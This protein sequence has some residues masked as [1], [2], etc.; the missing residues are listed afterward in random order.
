MLVRWALCFLLFSGVSFSATFG[1]VV[2]VLG[3]ATDI[4]LDEGRNRIYLVNTNQN[5]VE[6]YSIQQRR[7]L[8]PILTDGVPLTAAISRSGQFLYVTSQTASGIDVIDL[9]SQTVVNRLSLPA[10]PEGI[11]VGGD[12]RVLISTIGS[13]AGNQQNVLLIYDPNASPTMALLP[14]SV[15]PLPPVPPQLPPPSGKQFQATRATLRVSPDGN[16]IIGVNIPINGAR[17]VFVYEVASGTVLRSRIVLNS[18][19]VLAVAPDGSKFMSGSTLFDTGTLQVL[20][21]ENMA[22]APYL[23]APG[24]AFNAESTQGGS[25][26]SPDGTLLFAGFDSAPQTN[27]PSP[28]NVSQLL[29]NDPDNLLIQTALQLPEN[30]SGKMVMSSDGATIY[31]LSESGF[32]ILPLAA[33]QQNPLAALDRTV[34]VLA[35]DQCGVTAAQRTGRVSVVN[36]GTG[37]LTA[38]AQVTAITIGAPF[39]GIPGLPI[40]I[41]PQAAAPQVR[42]QQTGSGANIDFTFNPAAAN[43]LGTTAPG[44]DFT[45]QSPEAINIPARVHVYQNNRNAEAIGTIMPLP[46]GVSTAEGLQDIVYDSSRQRLYISNS[47]MNRVEVFD[48]RQNRF[49]SPIK[50]GQLPHSMAL[51]PDGNT[52]YVANTGGESISIVDPDQGQAVGRVRFPPLPLTFASVLTTPGEIAAGQRGPLFIMNTAA[53]NGLGTGT[54]WQVIG[55]EAV[56]R[57]ASQVIGTTNGFPRAIPGPRSMV[58]TPGGEFILL[59]GSDGFAYLYDSSADDFVQAKQLTAIQASIGYFGPASAGPRGQYFVVNGN[60]LNQELTAINSISRTP[61]VTTRPISAVTAMSATTYLRFTTP[62][63][64]NLNVAPTDAGT[65]EM[66]DVITGLPSRSIPALE[67]PMTQVTVNQRA[68]AI[69]SRTIAIDSSGNTAYALTTSGLSIIS[70]NPPA[71]P[72]SAPQVFAKG[73]VNAASY[74]VGVAQNGIASIFGRNLGDS[75]SAATFPLPTVMGGLCVTLNST[76]LPLFMT[77]PGQINLQIPPELAIGNYALVIR[78]IGKSVA[79]ASQTLAVAKYAPAV[80]VDPVTNQAALLHAS[81]GSFVTH[82]H[83]AHR[84][85]SLMLFATGLGLTTGGKVTGGNPSPSNPLAVTAPVEVFFGNPAWKQAGIIVDW[86]GLAPGFVGLYQLNLRVP[87][88]HINGDAVPITLRIGSVSSPSSG[89]VLPVAAVE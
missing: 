46:L 22:N 36:V 85:E 20:A 81:D 65:L 23:I 43:A 47:G 14:V 1:T 69:G 84:D 67:G 83:P 53:A 30:L 80:F 50:V 37:R 57:P 17:V 48:I 64:T 86:S 19:G 31:A 7:L 71:A 35:N 59:A 38:T 5:R 25:V 60:V 88:D 44:F 39:P 76:P 41:A 40:P 16:Y 12:E 79:S 58:A 21:Q 89:P 77:S 32:M 75:A 33:V 55:D 52:L 29:V 2:P 34:V 63:R 24:A 10:K 26:F 27:P 11:A 87:G 66:V 45:V 18:S 49:V 61:G 68:A 51:T 3:G 62:I 73:T 13:G 82:D 15:A 8:S 74:Q 70:L 42:M 72:A 78:A 9:G 54:I 6:V 28:P 4:V 56:P